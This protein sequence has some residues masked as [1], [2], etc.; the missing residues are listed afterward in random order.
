MVL[1]N[2]AP[3][4]NP[5]S[6]DENTDTDEF[7]QNLG[8]Q[9]SEEE[10]PNSTKL[11]TPFS[12]IGYLNGYLPIGPELWFMPTSVK[13]IFIKEFEDFVGDF[14]N[15]TDASDFDSILKLID[16]LNFPKPEKTNRIPGVFENE[17]TYPN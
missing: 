14:N 4:V 6:V 17:I 2:S 9:I 15:F 16:P 8:Q 7:N 3:E 12:N 1:P 11:K 5:N 13:Q 10:K